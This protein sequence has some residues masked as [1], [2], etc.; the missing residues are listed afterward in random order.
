MAKLSEKK[1]RSRSDWRDPTHG[2]RLRSSLSL[3]SQK[4]LFRVYL[5]GERI[6]LKSN[7]VGNGGL[8]SEDDRRLRKLAIERGKERPR[9]CSAA[10]RRRRQLATVVRQRQADR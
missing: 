1:G 5:E 3:P 9:G 6:R 2:T 7:L 10:V 4:P 8:S